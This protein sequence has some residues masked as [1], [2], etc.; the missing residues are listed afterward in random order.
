[1]LLA[2]DIGNT[3]IVLALFQNDEI[4]H[5][6]RIDSDSNK[7]HSSYAIDLVELFLNSHIDC[8]E[9]SDIIVASVVPDL[10]NTIRLAF[11][12][13]CNARYI[14]LAQEKKAMSM[15]INLVKKREVGIDRLINSKIAYKKFGGDLM[16]ID[17]G[18]ATTF[19]V[20]GGEGEYLGGVISPGV[21]LSIRALHEET[22][23]LPNITLS[24]QEN[25]IGKSTKEAM[26]SGIYFGYISLVEG[27]ILRI[28]NEYKKDMKII[29][30]GG[31]SSLFGGEL[32]N[33][34][35]IEPDLTI[36][37]IKFIFDD[38]FLK[39]AAQQKMQG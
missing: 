4:I 21:N 39:N 12:E 24:K 2:I 31:L 23:K 5:Q 33:I 10:T 30:T 16:I 18:T 36:D 32:E 25:V 28:K 6:Y 15:K 3:N 13:F 7:G 35:H 14:N 20:V 17:F 29:L 11:R 34:D 8:L 22:A 38:Y 27:L 26:N 37:G 9:I 19:D 1:M